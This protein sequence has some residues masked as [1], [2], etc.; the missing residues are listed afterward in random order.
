MAP[1]LDKAT[2]EKPTTHKKHSS[3]RDKPLKETVKKKGL[4]IV[5]RIQKKDSLHFF[6]QPVDTTIVT[7][8]LEVIKHPMDLGTVQANLEAYCYATFEELWQDIDLIW[9][10]CFTY[11]GP[12]TQVHQCALR[13]RKFSKRVF[14][15]LCIFLRKNG[16]EGEARALLAAIR[17]SYRSSASTR[18]DNTGA[19][20]CHFVSQPQIDAV[21]GHSVNESTQPEK[22]FYTRLEK[23]ANSYL[24]RS[25]EAPSSVSDVERK[26]SQKL[27]KKEYI[28]IL[29]EP[30]CI[31]Q[32]PAPPTSTFETFAGKSSIGLR[33]YK[34][35]LEKFTSSSGSA[36]NNFVSELL[37]SPSEGDSKDH[38]ATISCSRA[39]MEGASFT[40]DKNNYSSLDIIGDRMET[41]VPYLTDEKL[42]QDF[43]HF[44]VSNI[45]FSMPYGVTLSELQQLF[46]LHAEFGVPLNF[47]SELIIGTKYF[48]ERYLSPKEPQTESWTGVNRQ[49][50]SSSRAESSHLCGN[51]PSQLSSYPE[52]LRVEE[53][54]SSDSPTVKAGREVQARAQKLENVSGSDAYCM[55]CGTFKSPGWRAGPS[56]ARRLCNACGLFWAKHKQLRPKEKWVR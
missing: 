28:Y 43:I 30:D 10:N 48:A 38:A 34:E 1:R 29:P 8:Y 15:D 52:P 7:D 32:L 16:L 47:L 54:C 39:D 33:N 44:D 49:V 50:S 41:L 25:E 24:C 53:R 19:L 12:H 6:A 18:V 11:N 27:L 35:S 42:L 55:N 23:L 2:S 51:T 9:K 21:Q 4:E 22:D 36:L 3:L 14:A 20:N 37:A 46:S 13:L 31:H 5:K 45:D 40:L 17:R 26:A 56:H